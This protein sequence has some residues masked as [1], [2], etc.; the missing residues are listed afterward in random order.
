VRR[1]PEDVAAIV[2]ALLVV[3]MPFGAL[4]V[5]SLIFDDNSVTVRP[6]RSGIVSAA[7]LVYQI[8]FVVALFVPLALLAG[9]RTWVHA[10]RYR[11]RQGTGWQGVAEAGALGII[12]A[13]AVLA[14]GILSRPADAL[15]Y[16]VFYGGAALI[17]GLAIGVVLRMTALLVLRVQ[18]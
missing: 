8:G 9:W 4:L 10:R 18:G 15:P 5:G 1:R 6:S 2:N 16:V 13:L 7:T 17:L 12:L 3:L 11:E 14:H